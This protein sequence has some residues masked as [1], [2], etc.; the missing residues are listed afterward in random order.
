MFPSR[1]TL[2]CFLSASMHTR[3]YGMGLYPNGVRRNRYTTLSNPL[4]I[5]IQT[6]SEGG[7]TQFAFKLVQCVFCVDAINS[8]QCALVLSCRKALTL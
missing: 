8:K 3:L 6:T 1:Q 5:R 7:L 4:A 2:L